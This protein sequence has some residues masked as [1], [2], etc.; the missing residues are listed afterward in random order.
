MENNEIPYDLAKSEFR[1]KAPRLEFDDMETIVVEEILN[2]DILKQT[3]DIW[4]HGSF[5]DPNSEIDKGDK[6]SDLDI[7][8]VV[9][10]WNLPAVTSGITWAASQAPTLEDLDH[11][12]DH[13]TWKELPSKEKKWNCTAEE[14]W[15]KLPECVRKTFIRASHR[16]FFANDNDYREKKMRNY[17]VFIGNISQFQ[18]HKTIG[19]KAKIWEN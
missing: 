15:E 1:K 3:R 2:E 4:L 19:P 9:P 5:I 11:L 7:F 14:A 13:Y 12:R 10:N 17:D 6:R 16:F 8:V 18:Y